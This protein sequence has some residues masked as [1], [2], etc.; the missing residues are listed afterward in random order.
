MGMNE[1]PSANRVQIGIFGRVNAG[2]SSIINAITGQ[3]LAI[4][5]GKKGTTTDPVKKAMELLPLGPVV[6]IDTPGLDDTG[7]LGKLR[8]EKTREVLNKVDIAVLAVDAKAADEASL[9][10]IEEP[11]IRRFAE[12]KLP[13]VI[14]VNKADR[15]S[16][17]K[18]NRLADFFGKE[19][20]LMFV[21]A[22]TGQNILELKERIAAAL[23]PEDP[24]RPLIGDLLQPYDTVVL[25]VP[26]DSAAPK[27][28]LILPQQQVIR[29]CLEAGAI[30]VVTRDTELPRALLSLS[31]KPK[32]VI[33]DSQAFLQAAKATPKDVYLTSFSILF[34]RYKG[35][36]WQQVEGTRAIRDL[37]DGDLVLVSE[38]C[39]HHRQCGDIGT[40]KLPRRIREFT[41]KELAFR[42]T[43]GGEFPED[44]SGFALAIHCGGC[45][46][47]GREMQRRLSL[48]RASGTPMT[49]YGTALA[50]MSGIL[51]RSLE[52][53]QQPQEGL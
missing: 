40:Q 21:S 46:L 52:L 4:I 31:A 44:L 34:S 47:N 35:D 29:D 10:E 11:L 53:F 27:G 25:V 15:I 16:D 50:Y 7:Y 28:R 9:R 32:A 48:A 12:Q 33:T 30:P 23:P 36:L 17:A 49:N 43:S 13:Y 26:I 45:T 20:P 3:D 51:K 39:T 24:G 8:V 22:K 2:K 6:L 14:A 19:A 18:R 42:F 37:K 41:G 38:G 1:T 5:S